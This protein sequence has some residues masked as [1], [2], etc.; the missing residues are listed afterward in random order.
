M[1]S[2]INFIVVSAMIDC[3][4]LKLVIPC[5]HILNARF[6]SLVWFWLIHIFDSST[7]IELKISVWWVIMGVGRGISL[8]ESG[9]YVLI[10]CCPAFTSL[11]ILLLF[12]LSNWNFQSFYMFFTNPNSPQDYTKCESFPLDFPFELLI[13]F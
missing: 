11:I 5:G 4:Q 2:L 7:V 8:K 10:T 13:D 6:L 3:L 9:C 12:N 1:K